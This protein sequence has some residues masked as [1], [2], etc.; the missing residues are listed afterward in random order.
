MAFP[1]EEGLKQ[2][3]TFASGTN[4]KVFM[5]FPVEEGLKQGNYMNV[6]G[7]I[8]VFMAFPV[9]EGLKLLNSNTGSDVGFSFYGLSSRRRIETNLSVCSVR[10]VYM[11]LWPFQ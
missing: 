9:E 2:I 5:A 3:A 6:S 8:R 10:L 1:V 11:F 4:T 7:P